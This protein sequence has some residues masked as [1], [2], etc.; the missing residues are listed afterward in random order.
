MK[1]RL[2]SFGNPRIKK[3]VN[4]LAGCKRGLLA[5]ELISDASED[6]FGSLLGVSKEHRRVWI[7]ED[8]I[9]DIRIARR[10]RALHHHHLHVSF[11]WLGSHTIIRFNYHPNLN[12]N[13]NPHNKSHK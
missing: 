11:I 2:E 12:S 13:A 6:E 10:H 5:L 8:R 1:G 4:R 9:R 7:V 3:I